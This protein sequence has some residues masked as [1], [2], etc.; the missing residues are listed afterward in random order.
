MVLLFFQIFIW[1]SANKCCKNGLLKSTL[2]PPLLSISGYI[3]LVN[4]KGN[5]NLF[6]IF[7]TQMLLNSSWS[8]VFFGIQNISAALFLLI[9]VLCLN[10]IIVIKS[11]IHA[12][13]VFYLLLPYFALIRFVG[14][15]NMMLYIIYQLFYSWLLRILCYKIKKI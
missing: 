11:F 12:R 15:L 6:Y 8:Y 3:L 1:Y 7:C 14:Y 5:R 4:K 9:L 10:L 2:T 13:N